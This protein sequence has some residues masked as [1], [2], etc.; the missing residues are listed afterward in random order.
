MATMEPGS[1][2]YFMGDYV[3]IEQANV[4][5]MTHSFN[6]GTGLFEGIR[7]YYSPEEPRYGREGDYLTAPTASEWYTRTVARFLAKLPEGPGGVT[8]VDVASGDGSFIVGV[9][10]ALAGEADRVLGEIVS[11]ERSPAMKMLQRRRLEG[12]STSVASREAKPTWARPPLSASPTRWKS[13]AFQSV[14]AP[15]A[16]KNS[17]SELPPRSK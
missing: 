9:L 1:I 13:V 6:Y 7:G 3:P 16:A 2:A 8:L 10:D 11:I 17:A 14:W 5:I 4:S 12:S 15:S